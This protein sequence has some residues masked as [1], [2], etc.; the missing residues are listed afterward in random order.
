MDVHWLRRS[1]R[2][3]STWPCRV[4]LGRET[5]AIVAF[6]RRAGHRVL[7][8]PAKRVLA[9]LQAVL[10]RVRVVLVRDQRGAAER[11]HHDQRERDPLENS[12][13]IRHGSS[14]PLRITTGGATR[15]APGAHA[16]RPRWRTF[17]DAA[18]ARGAP[19]AGTQRQIRPR[20]WRARIPRQRQS[21]LSW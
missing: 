6:R 8:G 18:S 14:V 17:P 20:L 2:S 7:A 9:V 16:L 3:I 5:L 15:H 13:T 1:G 19:P 21:E 11:E 12:K 4:L 10:E